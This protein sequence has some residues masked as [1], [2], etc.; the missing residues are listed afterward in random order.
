MAAC[1]ALFAPKI[2][3]FEALTF[4]AL[5]R[6]ATSSRFQELSHLPLSVGHLLNARCRVLVVVPETG[7]L[8]AVFQ[9][10]RDKGSDTKQQT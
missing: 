2:V 1:G 9:H 7:F 10:V 3:F 8:V 5:L 6:D 4:I